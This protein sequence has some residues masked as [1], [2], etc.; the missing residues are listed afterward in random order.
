MISVIIPAYN[1][2]KY[3]DACLRSVI[4]QQNCDFEI[5]LVDDGS[6]DN[7][8][9]ICLQWQQHCRN[10]HYLYQKNQGQGTAREVGINQA[11]GEW[12]VFLDADDEMLP[13]ALEKLEQ[14]TAS[15]ADIVWFEYGARPA[16]GEEASYIH[17][18]SG[19]EDKRK[20]MQETSTLLWD[21]MFR[22]SLWEKQSIKLQNLYGEDILPVFLLMVNASCVE[23]LY[24][25]LVLHYNR[26]DNLSA[27]PERV[28]E[29]TKSVHFTIQEFC[30]RGLFEDY[31]WELLSMVR[32][33]Y[34]W[35]RYEHYLEKLSEEII[36][37]LDKLIDQYFAAEKEFFYK[38]DNNYL[39]LIGNIDKN[40]ID[41]I[42]FRGINCYECIEKYLID[43]KKTVNAVC[44]LLI[45]VENE[46][47]N[48]LSGT[49]SEAWTLAR[50]ESQCM[51]L[52]HLR[53][54]D[55]IEGKIILYKTKKTKK[56]LASFESIAKQV[57][58]CSVLENNLSNIFDYLQQ[59]D[60]QYA[61]KV[62]SSFNLSELDYRVEYL[63]S[64]YIINVMNHWL[65][66]KING[67]SLENYFLTKGY[68]KIAIYG[69]G[70]LGKLIAEELKKSKIEVLFFI[71]KNT[72]YESEYRI[73]QPNQI[74]P[75]VDA[76][77]VSVV[78]CY[79]II[80]DS[81][82]DRLI[83]NCPVISLDEILTY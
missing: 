23:I 30:K 10:L 6:T 39:I 55:E 47:K 50:W 77:V 58:N 1:A 79:E 24:S 19:L 52:L 43:K 7:T 38:Y 64:E 71:D 11:R 26:D 53:E 48:V 33:Q 80:R 60:F 22:K 72:E 63:R 62:T 13:N 70:F 18:R 21:K 31:K 14:Y 69:Y 68:A 57:W 51:E 42:W 35:Y 8:K 67:Y 25:P 83:S 75:E 27:D 3:L 54:K 32:K 44:H 34:K 73:Y 81:F 46:E 41:A 78:H 76:I 49:R 5:I 29:I 4:Y 36:A 2:G 37:D 17:I 20:I 28:R 40:E 45:N 82:H 56:L 59:P 9:E 61:K 65:N 74:I 66:L 16:S 15:D 12:L